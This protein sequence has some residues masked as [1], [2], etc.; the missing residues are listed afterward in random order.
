MN[1]GKVLSVRLR[2]TVLGNGRTR[3]GEAMFNKKVKGWNEIDAEAILSVL[4]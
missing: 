2:G 4:V 3:F 1:L